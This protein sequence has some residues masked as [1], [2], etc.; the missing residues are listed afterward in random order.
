MKAVEALELLE[1]Y[2]LKSIR[3][4][5]KYA[6]DSDETYKD[7]HDWLAQWAK[8][9][10]LDIC[11]GNFPVI[12]GDGDTVIGVDGS[13]IAGTVREGLRCP[14]DELI[15]VD[16]ET[17]DFVVTNHLEAFNQPLKALH[18]WWRVLKPNGR[19]AILSLDS[20]HDD[21]NKHAGPLSNVRRHNCFS[22]TTLRRY[23]ERAGFKDVVI[24]KNGH[25]LRARAVK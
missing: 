18:E 23:L 11:C 25:F 15:S 24:E 3:R 8:G 21:Y 13:F 9:T 5:R 14:G 10:G 12:S 19:L 16:N 1:A 4:S 6:Q 2:T 17:C 20:D 22:S 7:T